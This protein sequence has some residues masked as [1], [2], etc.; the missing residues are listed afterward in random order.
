MRQNIAGFILGLPK[1]LRG[2]PFPRRQYRLQ[3]CEISEARTA[4][5]PDMHIVDSQLSEGFVGMHTLAAIRRAGP[6]IACP[7]DQRHAVPMPGSLLP[8]NTPQ[9]PL[10]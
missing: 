2:Y 4:R 3:F 1:T 9:H 10:G 8:S 6:R 5:C 7:H